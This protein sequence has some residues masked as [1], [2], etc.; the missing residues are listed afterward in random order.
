MATLKSTP[1]P[2]APPAQRSRKEVCLDGWAAYN[3]SESQVISILNP[4]ATPRD[5]ASFMTG[6]LGQVM[7]M[8]WVLSDVAEFGT[9]HN[10]VE[11][12]GMIRHFLGP[13]A[14]TAG[15][16]EASLFAARGGAA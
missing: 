15:A 13:V 3:T 4:E 12:V 1:E 9:E 10:L 16:L 8:L 14:A 5:M 6:Q 11:V 2:A 7:F